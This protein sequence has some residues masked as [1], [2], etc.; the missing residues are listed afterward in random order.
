MAGSRGLARCVPFCVIASV[1]LTGCGAGQ[2]TQ[3]STQ[4]AAVNGASGDVGDGI[5]L[6]DVWIPFPP[7]GKAEYPVGSK[8]PVLATVVNDGR[9][10]DEL[11]SVTSPVAGQVV[12]AG[13]TRVPPGRNVVSTSDRTDPRSPLIS[14]TMQIV[15]TTTQPVRTGL[16]VPVTFRFREA[17]EV[18]LPV[19]MAAP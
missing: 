14:G 11:L 9:S 18:T 15:L 16:D 7:G 3:T 13:D 2:V 1:A 5:A 17:G 10:P 8:V 19:P 12:V 6:R 4:Q